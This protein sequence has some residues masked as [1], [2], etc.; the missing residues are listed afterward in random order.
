MIQLP[1]TLTPEII[2]SLLSMKDGCTFVPT[3]KRSLTLIA[4][5]RAIAFNPP[6]QREVPCDC[7]LS[8]AWDM[9]RLTDVLTAAD[10][11]VQLPPIWATSYLWE[12]HRF[13]L[14][15]DGNHRNEGAKIQG[16]QQIKVV[17]TGE[18][19]CRTDDKTIIG[20]TLFQNGSVRANDLSIAEIQMLRALG[21]RHRRSPIRRI[22]DSW[23]MLRQ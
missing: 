14:L 19:L 22:I 4:E 11:G 10:A 20:R 5:K 15:I 17:V 1:Q 8:S 7:V 6:L 12:N 23:S 3:F 13:Y 2:R 18:N 21:V 9:Q 16:N